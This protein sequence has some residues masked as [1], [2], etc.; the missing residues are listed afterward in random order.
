MKTC[1]TCS[2]AYPDAARFCRTCGRPLQSAGG[3]P[4]AAG[5]GPP[6]LRPGPPPEAVLAEIRATEAGVSTAALVLLSPITIFIFPIV[7][8]SGWIGSHLTERAR[9]LVRFVDAARERA[10]DD[11]MTLATI[12]RLQSAM[13]ARAGNVVALILG[14]LGMV[15]AAGCAIWGC[16]LA[17]ETRWS[18]YGNWYTHP[19]DDLDENPP[20]IAAI[21]LG[22]LTMS[23]WTAWALVRIRSH[24]AAE[25]HLVQL[26]GGGGQFGAFVI[27]RGRSRISWCLWSFLLVLPA[28]ILLGA[29]PVFGFP[30]LLGL[31]ANGHLRDE[32][33]LL[34]PSV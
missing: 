28:G 20:W 29:G 18:S 15:A 13:Q 25:G 6:P 14:I 19:Y 7:R 22:A 16:A 12:A 9:T 23:L 4:P 30:L 17:Q 8:I 21:I 11:T 26:A 33:Q 27:R 10:G 24:A 32:S 31:A 1:T 2:E 34:H 3:P 5:N